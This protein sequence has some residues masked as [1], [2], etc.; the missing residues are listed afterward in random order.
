KNAESPIDDLSEWIAEHG[1]S[2]RDGRW[3]ADRRD[4]VPLDWAAWK[5]EKPQ[6]DWP[7]SVTRADLENMLRI[8][9][10]ELILAGSWVA[11]SGRRQETVRV[12]SALVSPEQS[13]ALVRAFQTV[14]DPYEARIP[15]ADGDGETID[16]GF[17]LSGWIENDRAERLLDGFD[18]WAAEVS[19]PPLKPAKRVRDEFRLESDDNFRIWRQVTEETTRAVIWSDVWGTYEEKNDDPTGEYGQRLRVSS[20]FVNELLARTERDLIVK[21]EIER[22]VMRYGYER[23]HD[24]YPGYLPP[25]FRIFLLKDDGKWRTL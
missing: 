11:R 15:Y 13:A 18:P 12:A 7:S 23:G 10:D 6:D 3:L 24:D 5:D 14:S 20:T 9:E 16:L 22:R 21:V 19:F 8:G 25:Y 1:L 4:P 2:R 17:K